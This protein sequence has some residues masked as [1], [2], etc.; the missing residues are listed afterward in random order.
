MFEMCYAARGMEA[1]RVLLFILLTAAAFLCGCFLQR[2][3]PEDVF[4]TISPS[5]GRVPYEATITVHA[6][7]GTATFEL[8]GETVGPLDSLALDVVVD[9]LSWAAT[10]EWSNGKDNYRRSVSASGSNPRPAIRCIIINGKHD[11]WS[12]EAGE[13]TL[14]EADVRYSGE[15]NV[16]SFRVTSSLS[17]HEYTVFYPP[18]EPGVCHALWHGWI[19]EDACIFYPLYCS[20]ETDGL[21]ISPCAL[22][23]GYPIAGA[24]RT[25]AFQWGAPEDEGVEIP[26]HT[27]TIAVNVRDEWGRLTTRSFRVPVQA[28]DYED[29]DTIDYDRD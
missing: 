20:V 28:C 5:I 12:L 21:P 16:E 13:R 25:N 27:A 17:E 10:I 8:P 19:V 2:V 4:V 1:K 6:P 9:S 26:E 14:I 24:T 22:D 3:P 18:Y 15:C 29:T 11:L 23:A 7:P